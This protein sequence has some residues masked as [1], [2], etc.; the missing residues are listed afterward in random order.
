M[1]KRYVMMTTV[2]TMTLVLV[3]AIV[4]TACGAPTLAQQAADVLDA[5]AATATPQIPISGSGVAALEGTL[6]GIYERV[7]PSVVNIQVVQKS[8]QSFTMPEMP[9]LPNMPDFGFEIPD[10]GEVYQRGEGSGFVWDK[11]GH[12][13]TNNH[14]VDGADKISVT[15]YDGETVVGQVV[16]ADAD[17][18]LA[19]VKVDVPAERLQPVQMADSSQVKVGELVVAIGNPYGLQGTMT[20]GFVS[21]LGRSLPVE[22]GQAAGT[23]YTIP[24]V[25]QTDAPIN[26]G[27]SGGVLIDDQGKV[28]GVTSAIESPVR[29]SVGI[30][31]AIPSAI[32]LKIVPQLISQGSYAHPHI[33]I[34]G[35]TLTPDMA[36]AMNLGS[37]QRGALVVDI[38]PGSAADSAGLRGSDRQITIDGEQVRV[39]GDV[40][41]AIDGQP[42]K[43]FDDVVAYLSRSTEVGQAITLTV[44]R[45]GKEE[46]VKLTLEARPQSEKPASQAE[47]NATRG[48]WLGIRGLTLNSQVAEAMN[49]PSAQKGVLVQQVE[50]GS[51]ADEA[52]LKG[53][54]KPLA[55][56]GQHVLIGG[57]VITAF[58]GQSVDRIEALQMMVQ[59]A[60]AGQQV[61]LT[62][63]RDGK[64]LELKVTLAERPAQ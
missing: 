45:E 42:V 14:V 63:L 39:G 41:T 7:N 50:Q 13:V 53:S 16:G 3:F 25:I 19:V 8:K 46:T 15:F 62:L 33:G 27:N 43:K 31:Y 24:D 47:S 64:P 21:A 4:L 17:S 61:T 23:S 29:A 28:I 34:S 9:G 38:V 40:I 55:L 20:V 11:E 58:D 2:M 1:V 5:P 26:P 10:Q 60:Q 6:E 44:L 35:V 56:D 59:K 37:E 22:S 52:G 32:V 18:D 12:I 54:Y 48:A 51:P 36:Q 30:G 49:L 57:D